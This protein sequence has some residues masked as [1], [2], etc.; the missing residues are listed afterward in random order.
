MEQR[1][2]DGIAEIESIT[3]QALLQ[4]EPEQENENRSHRPESAAT[5]PEE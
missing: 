1:R 5:G 3:A 4:P 2:K